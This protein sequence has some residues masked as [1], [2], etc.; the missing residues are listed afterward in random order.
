MCRIG[1]GSLHKF[2]TPSEPFPDKAGIALKRLR[3]AEFFGSIL[4]P[5]SGH[6]VTKGWETAFGRDTSTGQNDD[7]L[8]TLK[9]RHK[10]I[11]ERT[12][13]SIHSHTKIKSYVS[14][15]QAQTQGPNSTAGAVHAAEQRNNA[16][17]TATIYEFS[18]K[19]G[20]LIV[21]CWFSAGCAGGD[22]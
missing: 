20:N 21:W 11:K 6:W 1:G 14:T 3:C 16:L 10:Q 2:L 9:R 5:Q 19:K 17:W 7:M 15:S 8:G 12:R 4:C 13:I 22:R 18:F